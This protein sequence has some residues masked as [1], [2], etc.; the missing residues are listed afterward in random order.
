MSKVAVGKPG[1]DRL[2]VLLDEASDYLPGVTSRKMFGCYALFANASIYALVWD[3][4]GGRIGLKLPDKAVY[5]ELLAMPGAEPWYAGES[6]MGYW[7]LVPES[8]HQEQGTLLKWVE[9]AHGYALAA[10]PK[11]KRSRTI[12]RK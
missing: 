2:K 8:F 11:P 3:K 1:L 9:M 12:R 6:R 7:V 10:P 4:D 5:D